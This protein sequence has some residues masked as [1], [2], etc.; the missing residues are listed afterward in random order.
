MNEDQKMPTA[1]RRPRFSEK[2]E[3]LL[4]SGT[5]GHTV[6]MDKP[7]AF[8]GA[9]SKMSTGGYPPSSPKK[10]FEKSL[11]TCQFDNEISHGFFELLKNDDIEM[12]RVLSLESTL[13]PHRN[14]TF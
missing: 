13:S 8:F 6:L 4:F 1:K 9:F 12:M 7:L 5:F 2:K 10:V 14:Q 3:Y 11:K